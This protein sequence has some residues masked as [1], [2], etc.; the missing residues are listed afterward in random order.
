MQKAINGEILERIEE[1]KVQTVTVNRGSFNAHSELKFGY[2]T[3]FIVMLEK[4]YGQKDEN[5]FKE[6]LINDININKFI[7]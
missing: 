1:E 4:P 2:C 5:E 7:F 6:F 3:E